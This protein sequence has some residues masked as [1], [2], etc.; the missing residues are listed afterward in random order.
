[1]SA[2]NLVELSPSLLRGIRS[3]SW[4]E[5]Q[6][7]SPLQY[8][9]PGLLPEGLSLLVGAP[10]TGKSWL[11]L[12]LC[13]AVAHG[14]RALDSIDV[15]P[16][17]V[18]YLALEDSERRLRQRAKALLRGQAIPDW[19]YFQTS[20]EPG[21]VVA[22]IDEWL[23]YQGDQGLVV[24]DTLGRVMP[25][26]HPGGSQYLHE[27]R[28]GARLQTLVS[29]RPGAGLTVIHHQ[30]KAASEDFVDSVSGTHGL[31]GA[32]DT[33][34]AVTRDRG[35]DE[36]LLRI[37]GRD[38]DET[39]LALTFDTGWT[40]FGCSLGAAVSA[41]TEVKTRSA[42]GDR[43]S[44]IVAFVNSRSE[45]TSASDVTKALGLDEDTAGRY[46]R[47]AAK[48]SRIDKATRGVFLPLPGVRSVRMSA[49]DDHDHAPS[50]TP[51]SPH[52]DDDSRRARSGVE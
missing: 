18:L 23:T 16:R 35:G 15:P 1:M 12:D 3:G 31:A 26:A 5:A 19:F 51:D 4:L 10:K 42:L 47:R 32:A 25:A 39:E 46:L 33:I 49:S 34:I 36:G 52:T 30:R 45:G 7:F 14:G 38:I 13:L 41:A 17:P 11:A 27:Y 43:S 9:V 29:R 40:L 28:V 37:T 48:A 21:Q 44:E 20:I 6:Q 8:I 24:I 22:L 2:E 50:D